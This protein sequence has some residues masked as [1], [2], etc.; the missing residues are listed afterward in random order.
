MTGRVVRVAV[1]RRGPIESQPVQAL[2]L[3]PDGVEGDRHFGPTLRAGPR[4]KGVPKGTVLPNTR[5]VSLVSAEESHEV[6]HRLGLERLDFTWLA[7]NVLLEGLPALSATTGVLRFSGGVE[8]EVEGANEPCRKVGRV[9]AAATGRDVEHR[10]VRTAFGLRG[11]V[12][13]V[14]VPGV[15]RVGESVERVAVDTQRA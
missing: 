10:F 15:I 9:I 13:F 1:C 5:Q 7:A 8:L 4:Q 12:G 2:V 3:L 6:A 14:R 11:V